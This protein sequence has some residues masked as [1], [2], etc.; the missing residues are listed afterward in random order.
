MSIWIILILIGCFIFVVWLARTQ[1]QP[2][3]A[4]LIIIFAAIVLVVLILYGVGV[5]DGVIGG[6]HR[7]TIK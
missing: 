2:P 5:F 6:G 4:R 3:T 1:F 7:I